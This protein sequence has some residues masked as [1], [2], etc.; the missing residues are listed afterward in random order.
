[1]TLPPGL[2]I[3]AEPYAS[4]GPSRVVERAEKELV[5]RY[6]DLH[7]A[8]FGLSA[9]MFDPP[10]GCFLVARSTDNDEPVGGVGLRPI[11]PATGEVK[12]LWVDPAR[13]GHGIARALM[14]AL[15]ASASE[16]GF[17]ALSLETGHRQPEAV[18]LYT[19][20]DWIRQYVDLDGTPLGPGHFR[21]TKPIEPDPN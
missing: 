7:P 18:A 6:A 19:A 15:E 20:T 21:F 5:I 8:E 12:R 2:T 4:D 10:L 14:A 11:G 17:T 1:M 16:L 13:R 3:D 9:T